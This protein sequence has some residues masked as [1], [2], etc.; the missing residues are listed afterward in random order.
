MSRGTG[1][2]LATIAACWAILC[3]GLAAA[4]HPQ[5][6]TWRWLQVCALTTALTTHTHLASTPSTTRLSTHGPRTHNHVLAPPL[7]TGYL[8]TRHP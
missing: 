8:H 5:L 6:P 4:T 1:L 2:R 3:M 7:T